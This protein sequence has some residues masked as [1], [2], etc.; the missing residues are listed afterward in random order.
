MDDGLATVNHASGTTAGTVI[1]SPYQSRQYRSDIIDLSGAAASK[2]IYVPKRNGR[3]TRIA[4]IY[5]E[6]SSA[7]AGVA[8]VVK[9]DDA[10]YTYASFT[11]HA[12][13]ALYDV[14]EITIAASTVVGS[15]RPVIVTSAGGKVGTGEFSLIFECDED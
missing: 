14:T 8:I 1:H 7:D 3:V 5:T 10:T 15:T 6:A 9:S 2:L 4:I 13:Q 11:S 12:S